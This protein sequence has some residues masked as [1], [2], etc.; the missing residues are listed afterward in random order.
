MFDT[1]AFK[2]PANFVVMMRTTRIIV[3]ALVM[4]LTVFGLFAVKRGRERAGPPAVQGGAADVGAVDPA[5]PAAKANWEIPWVPAAI[6]GMCAVGAA[7]LPSIV[8]RGQ[9]NLIARG[10]WNVAAN[11]RDGYVPPDDDAGKLMFAFQTS[12][13]IRCALIEGPAFF[14]LVTYMSTGALP[15]LILAG[16]LWLGLVA[17]FPREG[18]VRDWLETQLRRIADERAMLGLEDS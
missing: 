16:L 11:V 5:P 4:G 10:Q 18:A 6:A 2:L 1:H 13:I 12:T 14:C 17:Q 8:V 3:A 15:S 9:R 7:L